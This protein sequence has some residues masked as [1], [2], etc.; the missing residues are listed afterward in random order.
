[1]KCFCSVITISC[2]CYWIYSYYSTMWIN[3]KCFILVGRCKCCE[4][5]TYKVLIRGSHNLSTNVN[6][7]KKVG[8]I[9][10]YCK[11]FFYAC[12]RLCIIEFIGILIFSSSFSKLWLLKDVLIYVYILFYDCVCITN[13]LI[14][15]WQM[16]IFDCLC[17]DVS[18]KS[19][20]ANMTKLGQTLYQTNMIIY[21]LC[22]VNILNLTLIIFCAFYIA[23]NHAIYK[24][25]QLSNMGKW[26]IHPI[27]LTFA[28]QLMYFC[29]F[30]F[31]LK[32]MVFYLY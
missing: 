5:K 32:K 2:T 29:I 23:C 31:V 15:W 4:Y 16:V 14:H 19:F 6:V 22:V 25:E 3:L 24:F 30:C 12:K 20:N 9:L 10:S 1:L 26:N 13:K 28:M 8:T 27:V 17:N 21:G 18:I 7:T 11:A